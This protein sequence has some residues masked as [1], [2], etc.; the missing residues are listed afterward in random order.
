MTTNNL[1]S[2]GQTAATLGVGSGDLL[3]HWIISDALI[4]RF[5]V[6]VD[7]LRKLRSFCNVNLAPCVNSFVFCLIFFVGFQTCV[8][9][10]PFFDSDVT[11]R[12][13]GSR[14]QNGNA[15]GNEQIFHLGEMVWSSLVVNPVNFVELG[16]LLGNG[17]VESIS[18]SPIPLQPE[19]Q[20]SESESGN[21]ADNNQQNTH[22]R[23]AHDDGGDWGI[24]I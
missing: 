16:N 11:L 2:V 13:S 14:H 24:V 12:A 19:R 18:D 23:M 5:E 9:A 6:F 22:R 7:C 17:Q 3:G 8:E 20:Q 15:L 4:N 10:A 1:A 21:R